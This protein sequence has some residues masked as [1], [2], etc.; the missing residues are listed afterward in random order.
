MD[1]LKKFSNKRKLKYGAVLAG[2]LAI[3]I[4][5]ILVFNVLVSMLADRYNWYIDM[6][7]EQLYSV[8]DTFVETMERVGDIDMEIV[9]LSDEDKIKN[10]F[11]SVGG[12]VGLS[13]VNMT[14]TQLASRLPNVNVS[15]RSTDDTAFMSQ[16]D[17]STKSGVKFGETSV[18]VMR[19]IAP[20]KVDGNHFEV[21][22]PESFYVSDSNYSL[23]AY[24]GEAK[25]IE[26]AIRLT[27]EENPSAYYLTNHNC[28]AS[29]ALGELFKNAGFEYKG[30]NLEEKIYSCPCGSIYTQSELEAWNTKNNPNYIPEEGKA[31]IDEETG[32]A[33]FVRSFKCAND[34]CEAGRLNVFEEDMKLRTE[35][36][37]DAR[38][39]IIFEPTTD[40]TSQE[41]ILLEKYLSLKGTVMTFLDSSVNKEKMPNFYGFLEVQGNITI[42]TSGT[43]YVT[44]GING[45]GDSDTSFKVTIPSNDATNAFLP[46]FTGSSDS[47]VVTNAVTIT[48]NEVLGEGDNT[49]IDVLPLLSTS[50]YAVFNGTTLK[51][52]HTLMSI[53]KQGVLVD[54]PGSSTIAQQDFSSCL[55][56]CSSGSFASDSNIIAP[57]NSNDSFM[58]YLVAAT[59]SEQIY[60]TDVEFKVF[61]NYDLTITSNQAIIVL[62]LSMTILP[63]ASIITGFIV[64]RRRKQR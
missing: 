51:N 57:T 59:T 18:I 11:S 58:R 22:R 52:G 39:V 48:I 26:A 32:K 35:I 28:G 6:T 16:F 19:T 13:Y 29:N 3:V 49:T 38:A 37:S 1:F 40:F 14:A 54:N 10:D 44:D 53:S 30:I 25:I 50:K 42:N 23:F 31:D 9:F 55:L 64:I 15:Y 63:I 33:V 4:A 43:G 24:N 60:A 46:G 34:K 41:I 45:I 21:Y 62:V 20:G 56:V 17:L 12:L 2:F 27:Q 61:N 36:P 7:D 5:I 8:S 47:F